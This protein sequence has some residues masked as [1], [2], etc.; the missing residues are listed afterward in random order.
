MEAPKP[1]LSGRAEAA[2]DYDVLSKAGGSAKMAVSNRISPGPGT[3]Q[4]PAAVLCRYDVIAVGASAGGLKS[5]FQLLGPLPASLSVAILVVQHISPDHPSHL[6]EVME[7]KL[8]LKVRQAADGERM[9]PGTVYV[10]PPNLHLLAEPE[11]VRLLGSPAV[12]YSRPSIDLMFDSVAVN[13][14]DRSIGIV[15]SG[16]GRDGSSGIRNI[17]MAGGVTMTEDPSKAEFSAMPYAAVATGCVDIVLPLSKLADSLIDLC[18][19]THA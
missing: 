8:K 14:G 5:L 15:L 4:E 12:H 11:R 16:T 3:A 10:A 9:I 6:A 7:R 17:K 1:K 19:P 2:R 13:F 18:R